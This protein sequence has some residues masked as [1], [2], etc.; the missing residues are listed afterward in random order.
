M[1]YEAAASGLPLLVSPVNGVEDLLRDGDNGWFIDRSTPKGSRHDCGE[2]R[3]DPERRREM[4]RTARRDSLAY[5]WESGR[6]P[7]P[8]PLRDPGKGGMSMSM[9]H[10]EGVTDT[11]ER[12]DLEAAGTSHGKLQHLA[13]Y[14]WALPQVGARVLDVAC[15]TGYGTAILAARATLAGLDADPG[16]LDL[17]RARC[18]DADIREGLLP[19]LPWPDASFDT[20]V[21]FETIEHID[22]DRRFIAELRRVLRPGGQLILSTPNKDVTSPDGPPPNPWHVREYR[23]ADLRACSPAAASNAPRSSCRTPARAPAA[24]ALASRLVARVPALCRPG[25]WWDRLAHGDGTVEPFTPGAMPNYWV[26]R[27]VK[28]T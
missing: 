5:S 25:H 18:P 20:V 4:G 3:D 19:E 6:R 21:S 11:G 28:P 12:L 16:A 15:G 23:L 1:T 17:A 22:P 13:R 24:S 9:Q 8:R 14:E 27:A 2:L 7:V 26:L 10:V